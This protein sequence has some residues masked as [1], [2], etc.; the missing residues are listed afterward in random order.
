MRATGGFSTS[1]MGKGRSALMAD[2]LAAVIGGMTA[3]APAFVA[4]VAP[5]EAGPDL[6]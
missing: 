3:P 1:W 2:G 4:A 5:E 6:L